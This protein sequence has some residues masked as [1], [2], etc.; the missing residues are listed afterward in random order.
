MD[1]NQNTT[2]FT[3]VVEKID[4]TDEHDGFILLVPMGSGIWPNNY[5]HLLQTPSSS[6]NI[7]S[8]G[9]LH[10]ILGIRIEEDEEPEEELGAMKEMMYKI[11]L[12]ISNSLILHA[13]SN[14]LHTWNAG[15]KLF[16]TKLSA[17][18]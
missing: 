11:A 7:A 16:C 4:Q 9:F 2:T 1:S 13:M 5:H 3:N 17:K 8:S 18:I 10:D 12:G 14:L 15:C 6:S